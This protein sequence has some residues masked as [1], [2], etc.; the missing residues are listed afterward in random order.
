MNLPSLQ[1]RLPIHF[2]TAQGKIDAA[3][4]GDNRGKI[5]LYYAMYYNPCAFV[6]MYSYLCAHVNTIENVIQSLLVIPDGGDSPLACF[7]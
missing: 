7:G 6:R 4:V 5:S 3:N 2:N 1:N